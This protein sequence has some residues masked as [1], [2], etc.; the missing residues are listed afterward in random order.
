MKKLL[1]LSMFLFAASQY[2]NSQANQ[3]L[4]NLV[5][6]SINQSLIPNVSSSRD[7]GASN[8]MWRNLRLSSSVYIGSARFLSNGGVI[9]NTFTG[10]SSGIKNPTGSANTGHGAYTLSSDTTGNNNTAVGYS[11]L[12][13]NGTGSSNTGIGSLSLF[14]NTVGNYNSALGAGALYVNTSGANNTASGYRSLY[15]NTTGSNNTA[16]GYQSL[17]S[18]ET[19]TG[20]TATG[21]QSLYANTGSNNTA[22]GFY[23]L[24]SNT[25]GFGN[26]AHG[27]YSL[28]QNTSASYNTGM[29]Q[30][31]LYYD[32]ITGFNTAVGYGAGDF[33]YEPTQGTFLGAQ[34]RGGTGLTNIT[35]V[36][37]GATAVSSN[38]VRIG[39]TSVL[40]I[41]GFQNWTNFSDGRYKKN[42]SEKVPG[43]EF[44]NKLRPITY[45]LDVEGIDKQLEKLAPRSRTEGKVVPTKEEMQAKEQKAK[46]L[47]TGFVAQEVEEAA[48]SLSYDFSGVDVPKSKD[49]FYGLRYSDFVVPLVKSVQELSKKNDELEKQIKELRAL[50]TSKDGARSTATESALRATVTDAVLEQNIPNPASTS[51]KIRYSLPNTFSK[52]QVNICDAAGKMMK[53]IIL[54]SSRSGTINIDASLLSAGTYNYSIVVD[55]KT[56]DTKKMVIVR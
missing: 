12:Y 19:G 24:R 53:Q 6:T 11:V 3:S 25:T 4:S 50:I 36:G 43:L 10:T 51:T 29:G 1:S 55:G 54:G 41:G 48:K 33:T 40:S 17:Y 5:G 45:N 22:N 39:N 34:T 20:N 8:L 44:I 35:A 14:A 47:Q 49:E 13:R 21:Y 31:A 26:S 30:Y 42:Q 23:S 52:A 37:Y 15:S 16:N 46:V 56:I 27:L 2:A 7:L 18:N 38:S 32:S 9:S 28:W